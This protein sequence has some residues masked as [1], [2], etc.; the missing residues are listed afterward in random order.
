MIFGDGV[1]SPLFEAFVDV[2]VFYIRTVQLKKM[3]GCA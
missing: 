1:G 2:D 3:H